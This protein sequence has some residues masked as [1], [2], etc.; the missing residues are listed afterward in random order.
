MVRAV[1]RT[2]LLEPA[3]GRLA[4]YTSRIPAPVPSGDT[5]LDLLDSV[6][7]CHHRFASKSSLESTCYWIAQLGEEMLGSR[8][9]QNIVVD[10]IVAW[11]PFDQEAFLA[12]FRMIGKCAVGVAK[13]WPGGLLLYDVDDPAGVERPQPT[14]PS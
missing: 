14:H 9:S 13:T 4:V 5:L 7:H 12:R 6:P 2:D 1:L 11:C 3:N 8:E 10:G